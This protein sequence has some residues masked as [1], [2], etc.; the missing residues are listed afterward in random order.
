MMVL[1]T[2]NDLKRNSQGH[3]IDEH[4]LLLI[5]K[6]ALAISNYALLSHTLLWFLP[7]ANEV[8]G[9]VIFSV[10]CVKNSV[11]RGE[12]GSA[13][14]HA[15]IP[16]PKADTTPRSRHSPHGAG[17]PTQSRH[18]LGADTSPMKQARQPRAD[19]PW[20]QTPPQEQT[21]P[22]QTPPV[23]CMLGDT[24]HKWA[25]CILLECNLVVNRIWFGNSV[26]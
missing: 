11:H 1:I 14:V 22:E 19:T 13:S 20:E 24:V 3:N 18:P 7:P 4:H 15:G 25:V 8:R 10:A 23:Q 9:K 12:G 6:H 21:L 26:I 17:M 2:S 5:G 16:P